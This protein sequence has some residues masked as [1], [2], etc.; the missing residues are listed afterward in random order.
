MGVLQCSHYEGAQVLS[1]STRQIC[2]ILDSENE[3][4][5]SAE[6]SD[7]EFANNMIY[8]VTD[9]RLHR[10]YSTNNSYLDSFVIPGYDGVS[11]WASDIA[12]TDWDDVYIATN[13]PYGGILY[14][15]ESENQF[16]NFTIWNIKEEIHFT[17]IVWMSST[18]GN[19]LFAGSGS[20]P[21]GLAIIN[22]SSHLVSFKNSTHGLVDNYITCIKRRSNFLLLGTSKGFSFYDLE[23]NQFTV[24]QN[25]NDLNESF[26]VNAIEYYPLTQRVFVGTD[27]GLLVYEIV[28]GDAHLIHS[29]FTTVDGLS[30]NKVICLEIDENR[31]N[32]YMGTY[33]GLS[34][35]NLDSEEI[36][37]EQILGDDVLN[38]IDVE[39][40]IIPRYR[41][42]IYIAL[43]PHISQSASIMLVPITS[44]TD[45][46]FSIL[47]ST[48]GIV[49]II[50][51]IIYVLYPEMRKRRLSFD[52]ESVDL[53]GLIDEDESQFVERK[54]YLIWNSKKNEE[55]KYLEYQTIE[56]I[57][58][59]MNTNSGVLIIGQDDKKCIIGIEKEYPHVHEK[60]KDGEGYELMIRN[61]VSSRISVYA[62]SLIDIQIIEVQNHDV[63]FVKVTKSKQEIFVKDMD[64]IDRFVVRQGKRT[65]TLTGTD[66]SHFIRNTFG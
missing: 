28:D 17:E 54:P 10:F 22:R 25:R 15:D 4:L 20:T 52:I 29:R 56:A 37:I 1:E 58:A 8:A 19:T 50:V 23:K 7:E 66:Q 43:D 44:G 2:P 26:R 21:Y 57:A 30:S 53:L 61:L 65:Q 34:F 64:R 36:E 13:Q 42:Y 55:N 47:L 60:K 9:D 31:K 3:S 38:R 12:V 14:Y 6:W 40:I 48:G 49:S 41:N 33:S 24:S 63:C 39:S 27:N 51:A 46:V 32:L 5:Y 18:N 16:W 62:A 45:F 11:T 35:I 59:F